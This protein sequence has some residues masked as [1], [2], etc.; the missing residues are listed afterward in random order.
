MG[1]MKKNRWKVFLKD[2]RYKVLFS[3][4]ERAVRKYLLR[5]RPRVD[6]NSFRVL[7]TALTLMDD[8]IMLDGKMCNHDIRSAS[9]IL[10][11]HLDLFDIDGFAERQFKELVVDLVKYHHFVEYYIESDYNYGAFA[12]KEEFQCLVNNCRDYFS[13]IGVKADRYLIKE[14]LCA[15]FVGVNHFAFPQEYSYGEVRLAV[16]DI[17]ADMSDF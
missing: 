6:M 1:T 9:M 3:I 2:T 7:K 4:R 12:I 8:A 5:L 16:G 13:A 14:F 17:L 11:R 15:F 10:D